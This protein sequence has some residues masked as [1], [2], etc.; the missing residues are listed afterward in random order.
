MQ[1]FLD[2]V[3]SKERVLE[4]MNKMNAFGGGDRLTGTR[5]QRDYCAW[6]KDEIRAMG[7]DVVSK[8]Y[9]FDRW[10]AQEWS[11][12][13]DG[14][15]VAVSSPFHYS[16][17]TG[18]A[19][20]TA[21]LCAVC[22]NPLDFQRARGKIAV[23]HIRNLSAISSKVAFNKRRSLPADLE[24]EKSYRGPV[25]TSFVKTLLT[26]WSLRLAGV[27]GMICV[28]EDMSD[29]MVDGQCLNF[30]LGYLKVPVLWVNET[31]GK[32]VFA[33]AKAKKSATLRLTGRIERDAVTESFH[34]VIK[35]TGGT[36]EAIIVNTH[37]DGCNFSEENGGI[38]M[39]AMMRWFKAH[40]AK[41]NLIFVFVTGHFRLP[42]F[43]V[44]MM[45]SNQATGRWLKDNK[46][47]WNGGR[48]KAVAGC[49]VEHLGCT[50]WKDV[51]GV[52]T[53]T[54]D[55][56]TELVY[57]GNKHLDDVYYKAVQG[58]TLLRTMTL[59]GHNT[60]HFGEGQPLSKKHIPEIALVTAPDY[61]CS[62]DYSGKSHMDKFNLDLMYEQ[63]HT[64][65]RC[66]EILDG[67]TKKEI[68]RS[69]PYSL[70]LGRLK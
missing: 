16:G 6:L 22:N 42:V 41:R 62:V 11:L 25:S 40:P 7:I 26:F 51:N 34:A 65:V 49:S 35:G 46:E 64:F 43:R 53:R 59:R 66:V 9:R 28:W 70:G 10:E 1:L 69:Q 20:V 13:V 5:G 30:I 63:I 47:M 32:K 2:E 68:G 27:K 50:E 54:N 8:E 19:G 14:Q 55:I 45:T 57:T 67:M 38:G 56:D 12:T 60:M 33:A 31:E 39:L 58:R 29:A 15:P 23:C 37:T 52:Y 3:T 18:E 61:L 21:K 48:Y 44:G 24:V 36:D 4:D 17:L